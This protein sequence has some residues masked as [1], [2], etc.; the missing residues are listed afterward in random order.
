M[1]ELGALPQTNL[2]GI[3]FQPIHPSAYF[4]EIQPSP[5]G[6]IAAGMAALPEHVMKAYQEGRQMQTQTNLQ[7]KLDSGEYTPDNAEIS[8]GPNG[9]V[10][11]PLSGV[12]I[13]LKKAEANRYNA[14]AEMYKG[15]GTPAARNHNSAVEAAGFGPQAS[16]G[17]LSGSLDGEAQETDANGVP[18]AQS[19]YTPATGTT[20]ATPKDLEDFKKNGSFATGDNGKGYWGD[21]TTADVPYVALP[22]HELQKQFGDNWKDV[23]RGH[24]VSVQYGGKTIEAKIGDVGGRG[25]DL[26]PAAASALGVKDPDNFKDRLN[27]K[28][29]AIKP[30][31]ADAIESAAANVGQQLTNLPPSEVAASND[32]NVPFANLPDPSKQPPAGSVNVARPSAAFDRSTGTLYQPLGTEGITKVSTPEGKGNVDLLKGT[33][34]EMLNKYGIDSKALANMTPEQK[35]QAVIAATMNS[36]GTGKMSPALAAQMPPDKFAQ[37]ITVSENPMK[38]DQIKD[39]KRYRINP[40]HETGLPLNADQAAEAIG[41]HEADNQLLNPD[42]SKEMDKVVSM[43]GKDPDIK[44]AAQV[45][46]AHNAIQSSIDTGELNNATAMAIMDGY[47]RLINPKAAVRP[48]MVKMLSDGQTLRQ[49]AD[50]W[51]Q[52]IKDALQNNAESTNGV[53]TTK[54]TP[55]TAKQLT[56]LSQLIFKNDMEQ[57]KGALEPIKDIARMKGVPDWA[58]DKA[59]QHLNRLT[60]Q[61]EAKP[62]AMEV[63][64]SHATPPPVSAPVR[65]S[66]Q[67]QYDAL[68]PGSSYIDDTGKLKRKKAGK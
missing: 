50:S 66:S 2:P 3:V 48:M 29:G 7:K 46:S 18:I 39:L 19:G 27:Y 5:I 15:G 55:E 67:A 16:T 49:K 28:L 37:A 31:G 62:N 21:D 1:A 36:R 8:Y 30:A 63:L 4:R 32:G 54:L 26:N 59:F 25:I 44:N 11:K 56:D 68:P 20:F 23:A 12:E 38:P 40:T 35:N 61:P 22:E 24:P 45:V 14:M 51:M 33:S 57:T 9:A 64:S 58:V 41:Q 10:V 65:V 6:G 42:Q 17:P 43:M 47:N 53:A 52:N 60:E 34:D 13:N